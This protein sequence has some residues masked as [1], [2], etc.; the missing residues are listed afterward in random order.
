MS[1]WYILVC[2]HWYQPLLHSIRNKR[3]ESCNESRA[4]MIHPFAAGCSIR[5]TCSRADCTLTRPKSFKQSSGHT[6][7][8]SRNLQSTSEQQPPST[9]WWKIF[10]CEH[11]HFRTLDPLFP[12]VERRIRGWSRTNRLISGVLIART[13]FTEELLVEAARA[14]N[15]QS[16]KYCKVR[17]KGL[18]NDSSDAYSFERQGSLD[19]LGFGLVPNLR[20]LFEA[21]LWHLSTKD[22]RPGLLADNN[23]MSSANKNAPRN[24]PSM[25]QPNLES[26]NK[27]SSSSM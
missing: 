17:T 12:T 15:A 7:R 10:S 14:V 21:K 9:R 6:R 13:T 3:S 23:R 16:L 20:F 5:H 1:L 8:I 27:I 25:W 18:R 11:L 2:L 19:F 4:S 22:W 26:F 24:T